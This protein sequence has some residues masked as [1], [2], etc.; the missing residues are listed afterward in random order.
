MDVAGLVVAGISALGTLVQA[1]YARRDDQRQVKAS[2]IKKAKARASVP[3][4]TGTKVLSQVIDDTLLKAM[5]ATLSRHQQALVRAFEDQN[6]TESQRAIKVEEARAAICQ[7]LQQIKHF[8]NQT[9]PTR[10]LEKLW[11]SNRC[12]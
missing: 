2:T 7:T 8:N 4:K 11:E 3:L 9:L 5:N 1:Y 10:R 6:I 12:H